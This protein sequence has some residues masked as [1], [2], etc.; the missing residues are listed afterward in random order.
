[1]KANFNLGN[2]GKLS[3]EGK[4]N[5]LVSL[6]YSF[7]QIKTCLCQLNKNRALTIRKKIQNEFRLFSAALLCQENLIAL[8][9]RLM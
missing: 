4:R 1:M 3:N 6:F 9:S 7:S 2:E 5:K 8:G